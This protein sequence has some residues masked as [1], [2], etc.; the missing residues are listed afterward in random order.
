MEFKLASLTDIKEVQ[1][2]LKENQL[3]FED[4]I[5]SMVTLIVSVLKGQIIGCIGIEIK[6]E[7]GLLRSFSVSDKYRNQ[8]IGAELFK[9]LINYSQS[10]NIR[11]L[12]LLTTT[13]DKYFSKKGFKKSDRIK[14]PYSIQATTEF[15]TLCPA[16]SV[17]MILE[18]NDKGAST[19][20]L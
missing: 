18:I 12:H 2:L 1:S 8:G 9:K 14:A 17:Y 4:L 6:G 13:A 20:N 10:Q 5:A 3:P 16:S 11:S 7:V 19:T 15:S